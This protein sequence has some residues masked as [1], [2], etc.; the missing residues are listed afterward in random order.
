MSDSPNVPSDQLRIEPLTPTRW[1]DFEALF[2]PRGACGG[3]WCMTPRLPRAEYERGKGEG[4]RRAMQA[5]VDGGT[6]PGILGY[7]GDRAVA[8]CSV[9]P[10]TEFSWLAR[11]RLF[12]PLDERPVWSIVCLFIDGEHRREGLSVQMIEGACAHAA[13]QG[14]E[15]I[16][17]YPV[18]PKKDPMPPTFAWTGIAA[19]YRQ[20]G[21]REVARPSETRPLMRRELG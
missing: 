4:N 11:S 20:A 14:A 8:W 10:R 5:L 1:T 7:L 2:G 6:V 17:A 9:G 13:R 15:C 18:E 21:F 16:E 3:C 12:P 19:A